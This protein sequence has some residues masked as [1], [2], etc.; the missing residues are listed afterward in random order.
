MTAFAGALDLLF[1]D[2]N[3]AHEAW[4]RD[5]E[6]QFTRIHIIT[7]RSDD[8]TKFGAARLVSQTFR[9]DVRASDLPAPRPDEQILIGEE[10]FLIQGEPLR[11]RERLIW[12]IE[13]TPA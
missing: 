6:G 10:T 9:F 3:L 12:T 11:D 2:P 7:R 8:V 4:H 1:A 13:A 5:S